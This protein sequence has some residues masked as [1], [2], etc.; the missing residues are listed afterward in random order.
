MRMEIFRKQCKGGVP[1]ITLKVGDRERQL[2][3]ISLMSE[4]IYDFGYRLDFLLNPRN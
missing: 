3:D 2:K 1:R 4:S